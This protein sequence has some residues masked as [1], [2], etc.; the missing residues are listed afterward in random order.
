MKIVVL[1]LRIEEV[2]FSTFFYTLFFLF[3]GMK[4]VSK[5]NFSKFL[6]FEGSSFLENWSVEVSLSTFFIHYSFFFQEWKLWISEIFLNFF[7]LKVVFF[8]R[9][10]EVFLSTFFFFIYYSPFFKF[11]FSRMK[12]VS[13]KLF[14]FFSLLKFSSCYLLGNCWN[15]S[16]Y[17]FLYI[18]LPFF[19]DENCE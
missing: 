6:P 13:M 10:V 11:F 7:F 17:F 2:S 16:F 18:I 8:L 4:I 9:I 12:N 19:G 15:V 3:S 14:R 1:F 5:W